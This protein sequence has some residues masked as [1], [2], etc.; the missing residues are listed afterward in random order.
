MI[1]IA[2]IIKTKYYSGYYGFLH[3]VSS[4]ND[5]VVVI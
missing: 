3:V 1:Y 4:G 2:M 5:S